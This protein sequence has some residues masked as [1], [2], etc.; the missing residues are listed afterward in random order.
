M[1]DIEP[2]ALE[3]IKTSERNKPQSCLREMLKI[4]RNKI[5]PPPSWS[6]VVTALEYLKYHGL[7][8]DLKFKY[9]C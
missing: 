2:G 7:A 1:L 8:S 6:A 5:N 4:W 9:N 3:T